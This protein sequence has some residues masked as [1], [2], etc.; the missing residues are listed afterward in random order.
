MQLTHFKQAY[1][2]DKII[3]DPSAVEEE[4]EQGSLIVSY[5]PSLNEITHILHNGNTESALAAK[6]REKSVV[7]SH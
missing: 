7:K 2:H 4:N 3:L 6:V 1:V 5:M